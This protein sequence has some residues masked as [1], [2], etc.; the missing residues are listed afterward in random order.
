MRNTTNPINRIDAINLGFS[1]LDHFTVLKNLVYDLGRNRHLSLAA[2]GTPNEML[3]IS[4]VGNDLPLKIT[5]VVVLSNYDYDGY[6]TIEKLRSL[7]E[8]FRN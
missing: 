5:D 2:I 8:W 1:E 6:L 3:F 4:T 7:I